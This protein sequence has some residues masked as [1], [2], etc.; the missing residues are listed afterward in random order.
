[1]IQQCLGKPGP[2]FVLCK[3]NRSH[4]PQL[5]RVTSRHSPV[6]NKALFQR[7]LGIFSAQT[8]TAG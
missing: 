3:V 8:V 7:S 4:P 5:P 6:Q 2:H 1:V